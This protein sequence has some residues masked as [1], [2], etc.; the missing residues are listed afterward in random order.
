MNS[1]SF[2]RLLV[3]LSQCPCSAGREKYEPWGIAV[4]C[5]GEQALLLLIATELSRWCLCLACCWWSILVY[6]F[7]N[8]LTMSELLR[9]IVHLVNNC[10]Y[11]ESIF[12]QHHLSLVK[13]R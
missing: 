1:Q 6:L 13:S 9:L 12:T 2:Y 4:R 3:G 11:V 8:L 5:F 7:A 10:T